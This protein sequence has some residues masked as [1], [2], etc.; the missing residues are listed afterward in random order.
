SEQHSLLQALSSLHVQ[1][2][3]VDWEKLVGDA[4]NAGALELP[5]YAFQRA[6]YWAEPGTQRLEAEA[7]GM[8]SAEHP[9]LGVHTPLA[10]CDGALF[11][12]RISL[13]EHSWL[14]AYT[15]H[16]ATLLPGAALL[17]MALHAGRT[18][19]TATVAEL[20]LEDS[21]LLSADAPVHLQ[22]SIG[23][24]DALGQR[25]VI[26][27]SR[28]AAGTGPWARNAQGLL[29]PA[30]EP[31]TPVELEPFEELAQWPIPGALPI[32]LAD[33]YERVRVGGGDFGPLFRGITELQR[34]GDVGYA[35]VKLPEDAVASAGRWGLH[36]ALLE[37]AFQVVA[38][39]LDESSASSLLTPFAWTQVR[40]FAAHASELR[41]RAEL[42]HGADGTHSA[43]LWLSDAQGEPVASIAGLSLRA[44]NAEALRAASTPALE[45]LYRI[46]DEAVMLPAAA[47]TSA[48]VVIALGAAS[49]L[50]LALELQSHSALEQ[51]PPPPEGETLRLIVDATQP[52]DPSESWHTPSVR[53]L[54]LLQRFVADERLRKC[55]L[56][57]VTGG[58]LAHAPLWGLVRS[59]RSEHPDRKLRLIEHDGSDLTQ[60]QRALAV[61]DEPELR[62]RGGHAWAPRLAAASAPRAA[63][64]RWPTEP[65]RL[66]ARADALE[67]GPLAQAD[68]PLQPDELRVQVRAAGLFARDL[69]PIAAGQ[70][71]A[72][73]RSYAGVVLEV[74]SGVTQYAPGD[75]VLGLCAE[76]GTCVSELRAQAALAMRVP[77]DLSFAEAASLAL[78]NA[79]EASLVG[80]AEY[81]PLP[82]H[83]RDVRLAPSLQAEPQTAVV[84]TLPRGLDPQGT[85]LVTGG[86]GDLGAVLARHLVSTH[87]VKHLLLTSRRGLEA[88]GAQALMDDLLALGAHSVQVLACDVSERAEVDR[89]LASIAPQHPLN[90]VFHLAAVVDDG[91]LALQNAERLSNV[92][93]PKAD[94]ALHLSEATHAHD[95]AAF[96]MFSSVAGIFGGAG[97]S[98]YAAANVLLDA[99]A[100]QRS[101]RG[102]PA[103]SLAWGLWQLNGTGMTA[104][105][106][107]AHLARITQQGIGAFSPQQGMLLVDAALQLPDAQW[108]P[109]KLKIEQV[110]RMVAQAGYA[111]AIMRKL[112]PQSLRRASAAS[113][114]AALALRESLVALPES[115]RLG[116]LIA[117]VQT[118]VALVLGLPGP[119]AVDPDKELQK[120]GFDSLMAVELRNR[121]NALAGTSLPTTMAFDYPTSRAIAGM[122]LQQVFG[123][124]EAA[125]RTRTRRSSQAEPIAIVAMACRLPGGI[126]TP[127]AYW[128]LL[129]QG[130][131][132]ME[133]FPERWSSLD[134]YDPTGETAGKTMARE[135]GF[136]HGIELFDAGFFGISAREAQSMD[137]QQRL[138]LETAWEA[139]ERAGIVPSELSE[140]ATGVYLGACMS[141]Y[142]NLAIRSLE[143]LDGYQLTSNA[144]SVLSGR[145]SYVLG[146]QGPSLTLDSACSS[147]LV[148]VHLACNALRQGECDLALAGAVSLMILPSLFVEFSRL[149]GLAP[150][151]RC[152]GF[153][154][155]AD[156]TGWAEGCG[157][158]ALKRLSDAQRDGQRVL[159]LVRGTAVNQDGRSQGLTA[160]NG[161]SQQRV[162]REAL[163]ASKLRTHDIDAV[164]AHGTGT[165]LGDPIEATALA[166]LFGP[167]RDEKRP[168]YIGTSKSNLGHTIAAAGVV[169]VIKMVLSLQNE[170][171]P[172]TLY[173]EDPTPHVDW[174]SSGLALLQDARPWKR[175]ARPRRAGVSAFGVSGTNAH[176]VLEEAPLRAAVVPA[177]T[178]S[179]AAVP[180]TLSGQ[181]D[182]A[183]RAQ[184]QRLSSW[185][186]A[187]PQVSLPEVARTLALHRTHFSARAVVLAETHEQA[188]AALR[189]LAHGEPHVDLL[190]GSQQD[191]GKLAVLFTGQGSQRNGMGREL[192]ESSAVFRQA[193]DAVSAALEP[194]LG[195]RIETLM[196]AASCEPLHE[197]QY[198]QPA[199]FAL[200]V[201]LYRHWQAWGLKPDVVAGHSIGEL[202]AAHV[203]G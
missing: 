133:G 41:V 156:G 68:S 59:A 192:Y 28:V 35:C 132:A 116:A 77:S 187:H 73:G 149:R 70:E 155:R 191:A 11:S 78:R 203:A 40:L 25:S 84:L 115:E 112:L 110:Q 184:A 3:H 43:A 114:Q 126:D 164:E 180:L 19:G 7:F 16:E 33:F 64:L 21:L 92:L 128:E 163:A 81:A 103:T 202:S 50:A 60:L 27:H 113:S 160:P 74:G 36:P 95:L 12:S 47:D 108:V 88:P 186:E 195:L 124:L 104:G 49:P 138:V 94:A 169:G 93:R 106:S 189:A 23:P 58:E 175:G 158:L 198:T 141:E 71:R 139:L 185:L 29:R 14:Q 162:I 123:Q 89:A 183:L 39:L 48:Q 179:L 117:R 18:L 178:A 61:Q 26:V 100:L 20:T 107:D 65:S 45:H 119:S 56:T 165:A 53:A 190:T 153:S 42:A 170:L 109:L 24:S 194:E 125:P 197:T 131:D 142:S 167:E 182:A 146:L 173:A 105:L 85:V 9:L 80:L 46:G 199:L 181:D 148:A 143:D 172:K 2:Q 137:P 5:T 166:A 111:P 120:F 152:K 127:E 150:D 62:L 17:E 99:L 79:E 200:E 75:R 13:I 63:A 30:A 87:D 57:F 177:H 69:Q 8:A 140:S 1:G 97:Q 34:V 121:L 82:F 55:E 118:E 32:E 159:A 196:F 168:V 6:R 98:N 171:L 72:L 144:M 54:E 38:A 122:L 37:A 201:A 129:E 67:V 91:V 154:A 147:A 151:G 145:V 102:L 174:Q 135:G 157:I 161:P 176:V 193:L 10:D 66:I 31:L 15:V 86:T 76:P 51:V 4:R 96:V 52:P 22:L 136:V 83:A 188:H 90:A 101:Q 134:L 130:R 44:V